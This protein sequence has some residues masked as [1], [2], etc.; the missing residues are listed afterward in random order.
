MYNENIKILTM[1][2]ENSYLNMGG[3]FDEY[4]QTKEIITL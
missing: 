3:H 2:Q 1:Q 4:Q